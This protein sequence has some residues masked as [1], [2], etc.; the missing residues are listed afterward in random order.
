MEQ[1][2]KQK[3]QPHHS[4]HIFLSLKQKFI[5]LNQRP[6]EHSKFQI[7]QLN[8]NYLSHLSRYSNSKTPENLFIFIDSDSLESELSQSTR[9]VK[10]LLLFRSSSLFK[11]TRTP[12]STKNTELE[13]IPTF[14]TEFDGRNIKELVIKSPGNTE[15]STKILFGH[16]EEE[17]EQ[18]GR[19]IFNRDSLT[20]Y[21]KESIRSIFICATFQSKLI[22]Q[23]KTFKI[24]QIRMDV[25]IVHER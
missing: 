21:H 11:F 16:N 2:N 23:W 1:R 7:L 13:I 15:G 8:Q 18:I 4:T 10:T 9:Y 25:L 17:I 20:E 12:Y 19:H 3:C 6:L 24:C 5:I 14:E 22:Q